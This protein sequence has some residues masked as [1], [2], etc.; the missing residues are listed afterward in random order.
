[1][2]AI[3]PEEIAR[4]LRPY[5]VMEPSAEMVGQIE[6][7]LEVFTRWSQRMNLSTVTRPAEMVQRHFGE[8]LVLAEALPPFATLLDLGSGAGFPGLPIAMR[9]PDRHVTLAESQKKKATFLAEASSQM[10]LAVE[11]WA[12]RAEKLP[13]GR[14]FDVVALRAVDGMSTALK[15]AR[16]LLRRGGTLAFFLGERGQMELPDESWEEV[17][18]IPVP[19]SPGRLLLATLSADVPRGT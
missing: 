4:L 3:A 13:I 7:Y 17:R 2:N 9:W 14:S 8:S 11:V 12:G 5:V 1:M 19:N 16:S 18:T 10:N 15:V 6:C